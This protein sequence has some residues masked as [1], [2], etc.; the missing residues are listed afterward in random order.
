MRE[1]AIALDVSDRSDA[2]SIAAKYQG[3]FAFAKIGLELFTATGPSI[4][5]EIKDLGY[6]IFLDLKLHD[7]P[8]TVRGAT[9]SCAR[10]GVDLLTVHCAGGIEMI[11]AAVE[12][13]SSVE[14]G[15]AIVGV[16]QLTSLSP[17][18]TSEMTERMS[19][20]AEGGAHGFVSSGLE[21]AAI[22][23]RFP[24]LLAV[25]P[26]VRYDMDNL[27]DQVRVVTPSE[28]FNAGANVVV[29][30]RILH[31]VADIERIIN[32]LERDRSDF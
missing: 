3:K 20:I 8:N 27:G 30:G 32:F 21:V 6:R 11:R 22:K 23:A 9:V 4:I 15:P 1:Y 24:D 31:D 5:S 16:T 26:G 19:L 17:V 10:Y 25:V 28:A 14:G 18:S 12:A 29:L 2:T 13:S 7:I